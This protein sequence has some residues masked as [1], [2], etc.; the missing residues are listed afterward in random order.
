MNPN[1]IVGC[2]LLMFAIPWTLLMVVVEVLG[3]N[4]EY[5]KPH[6]T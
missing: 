5:D 4:V 3:F 1:K 6:N 2:M